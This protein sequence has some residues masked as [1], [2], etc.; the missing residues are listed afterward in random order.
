MSGNLSLPH[1][2][3][4]SKDELPDS[5]IF[6]T[7]FDS[8]NIDKNQVIQ[9]K[10]ISSSK[11]SFDLE[12]SMYGAKSKQRNE[13]NNVTIR[14]CI[15]DINQMCDLKTD[16]GNETFSLKFLENVDKFENIAYANEAEKEHEALSD[17]K[18]VILNIV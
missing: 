4:I 8:E 16:I 3:T 15:I 13:L 18:I 7:N 11:T 14:W 2:I 10:I 5:C 1:K 9:S 6:I 17:D 12:I